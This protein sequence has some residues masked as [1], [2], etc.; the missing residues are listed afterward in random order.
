MSF[1]LIFKDELKGFYK[2]K[3]MIFL[4]IGL[5]A[6]ALLVHASTSN[7]A[8]GMPISLITSLI[9]SSIGGLLA[10]VMLTVNII[11]EKD[12]RVYDLFLIRP[13][14][15][16]HLLVSKFLAVY[17]CVSI[18][19]IL[20]ISL[21]VMIDYFESEI[22]FDFIIESVIESFIMSLSVIAISSGV[23]ILIGV[24]SPSIVVGVVL[25]IFVGNYVS[26]IPSIIPF[27]FDIENPVAIV[28]A[29]G[30]VVTIILMALGILSFNRK[31]F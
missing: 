14:K 17:M 7:S 30:I 18:A 24:I 12:T 4:W 27:V 19:C 21:G 11:N 29:L 5:P 13:I 23:G 9:V 25:V 1:S 20:A 22:F 16:W 28:L 8:E 10:S 2:S 3:V 31:Q 26:S 6:L 15:R